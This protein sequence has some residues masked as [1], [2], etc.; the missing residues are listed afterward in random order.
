MQ[1]STLDFIDGQLKV[2]EHVNGKCDH[3]TTFY[4]RDMRQPFGKPNL[5]F[6]PSSIKIC[7]EK[8]LFALTN[9]KPEPNN[10]IN[11]RVVDWKFVQSTVRSQIFSYLNDGVSYKLVDPTNAFSASGAQFQEEIA[12]TM[13]ENIRTMTNSN[14]LLLV[15]NNPEYFFGCVILVDSNPKFYELRLGH[16]F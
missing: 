5:L 10:P 14:D 15:E 4:L 11:F 3:G 7:F 8:Q 2:W 16:Y 9:K 1:S 6:D 13:T 12:G